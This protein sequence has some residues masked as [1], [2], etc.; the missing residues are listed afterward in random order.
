MGR[1]KGK[2]TKYEKFDLDGNNINEKQDLTEKKEISEKKDIV[3]NEE[4]KQLR[5]MFSDEGDFKTAC[6]LYTKLIKDDFSHSYSLLPIDSKSELFKPVKNNK[7]KLDNYFSH[8]TKSSDSLQQF[9]KEVIGHHDKLIFDFLSSSNHADSNDADLNRQAEILLRIL[10]EVKFINKVSTVSPLLKQN[11]ED[12]QYVRE[13]LACK[14]DLFSLSKIMEKVLDLRVNITA[15]SYQLQTKDK[16]PKTILEIKRAKND[17]ERFQEVETKELGVKNTIHEKKVGRYTKEVKMIIGDDSIKINLDQYVRDAKGHFI[18]RYSVRA[19]TP[20]ERFVL[21]QQGLSIGLLPQGECNKLTSVETKLLADKSQK[22]VDLDSPEYRSSLLIRI[23][24]R[25][26]VCNSSFT[27]DDTPVKSNSGKYF[28][29][30]ANEFIP[31]LKANPT[32]DSRDKV[33]IQGG[34]LILIDL[35]KI[36]SLDIYSQG[37]GG[38]HEDIIGLERKAYYMPRDRH[39]KIIFPP[40]NEYEKVIGVLS[41]LRNR[42]LH[43]KQL[44]PGSIVAYKG[45][46]EGAWE[47]KVEKA[48]MVQMAGENAQPLSL[49]LLNTLEG[50]TYKAYLDKSPQPR[51]RLKDSLR[52]DTEKHWTETNSIYAAKPNPKDVSSKEELIDY[53]GV[54]ESITLDKI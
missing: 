46:M 24:T 10:R 44:S 28:F 52:R 32:R 9:E 14:F 12:I 45:Q 49:E 4:R 16:L 11:H 29:K 17:K 3:S 36:D 40:S 15:N 13:R 37:K 25:R 19:I 6:Q 33:E 31:Y 47:R 34:G 23:G 20:Q 30:Q 7:T 54:G 48:P 26:L 1:K 21:H 8:K 41:V 5:Q 38:A 35:A 22:K 27:L 43:A 51:K 42:E 53:N 39:G 2:F 50:K 18:R